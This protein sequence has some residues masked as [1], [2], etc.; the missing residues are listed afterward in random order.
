MTKNVILTTESAYKL[1]EMISSSD[2]DNRFLALNAINESNI[3]DSLGFIIVIYK[4]SKLPTEAWFE[5]PKIY[6][7]FKKIELIGNEV[8][9]YKS[10][11]S[12]V[13][14]TMV[15]QRCSMES[16]VM[17]LKL[18]NDSLV[19]NLKAWGYDVKDLMIDI[20]LKEKQNA[21]ES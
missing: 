6:D 8:N 5:Q 15:A 4:F 19:N 3:Q 20:N 18:H 11:T 13:L 7:A 9:S 2:K 12:K 10:N 21:E 16:I 14:G 17:F 1:I